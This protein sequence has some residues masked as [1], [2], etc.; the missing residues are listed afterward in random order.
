MDREETL[1]E[2]DCTEAGLSQAGARAN[3]FIADIVCPPPARLRAFELA[4][5]SSIL[6]VSR[7]NWLFS[8]IPIGPLM[9]IDFA[10][11]IIFAYSLTVLV[12]M[13]HIE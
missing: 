6:L 3:S 7:L 9:T 12:P 8:Y 13:S 1:K 10:G 11:R 2:L 5:S 4:T